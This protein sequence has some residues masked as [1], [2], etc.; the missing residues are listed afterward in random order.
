MTMFCP[1]GKNMLLVGISGPQVPCEELQ[2][3]HGG[4]LQYSVTYLLKERGDHVLV[5]KWGE[6]HVPG[7][8]FH[9]TVP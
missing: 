9:V 6:E 8:P 4:N 2:V 1:A 5:V 7:S 3:K